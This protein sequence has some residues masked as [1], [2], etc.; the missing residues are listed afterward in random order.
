MNNEQYFLHKVL[1][2]FLNS[3]SPITFGVNSNKTELEIIKSQ[4]LS[5]YQKI[6]QKTNEDDLELYLP[7]TFINMLSG[8]TFF[9]QYLLLLNIFLEKISS[10]Y[11]KDQD[12]N[13]NLLEVIFAHTGKFRGQE[14]FNNNLSFLSDNLLTTFT[15]SE[16]FDQLKIK[17]LKEIAIIFIIIEEFFRNHQAHGLTNSLID[18]FRGFNVG[19]FPVY[20]FSEKY[21]ENFSLFTNLEYKFYFSCPKIIFENFRT[22]IHSRIEKIKEYERETN[23][24]ILNKTVVNKILNL[25]GTP[26]YILDS[27][28]KWKESEPPIIASINIDNEDHVFINS[29]IIRSYFKYSSLEFN[30]ETPASNIKLIKQ[31]LTLNEFEITPEGFKF[32]KEI[33]IHP[34]SL[35]QYFE[36]FVNLIEELL[37]S[38]TN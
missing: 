12:Y 27:E 28:A 21:I 4:T 10:Q 36:E 19:I 14:K 1:N 20:L 32:S 3:P 17:R 2:D 5:N 18:F 35:C 6:I 38:T 25:F 29:D 34:I 33:S 22:N 8:V 26:K 16:E 7:E 23:S 15:K 24:V 13:R 37:K 11:Y 30:K 9:N 31:A